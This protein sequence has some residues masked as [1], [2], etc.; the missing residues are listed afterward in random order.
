[1]H[2]SR[3]DELCRR[4][5]LRRTA[6]LS[7]VGA[8]SSYALGLAG[9]GEL[10]AQAGGGGYQ[11]LVC[12]FLFG[13]N[14]HSNTL[15]PYDPA[16][17]SRYSSLRGGSTGVAIPQ[18]HLSS[19]VLQPIEQQTLTDDQVLALAP[20]L[21]KLKARF[22]E[23]VMAPI[24]NVG[25]L[26][27]PLTRA[28]YESSNTRAYP[29][30]SKL[31]SHNDQRST[32]LSFQ[33][34]GARTGW[35]GLLGDIALSSNRNAM[36]TAI[37]AGGDAVFLSGQDVGSYRI[38]SGGVPTIYN[39][40]SLYNSA[41]AGSALGTLLRQQSDHVLE[42]DHAFVTARSIDFSGF[43]DE[44]LQSA[45]SFTDFP[46]NSIL[47]QQLSLVSQLI[48]AHGDLG[49]TRQ[50][51]LVSMGGF[52]N[53]SDLKSTHQGLLSEVDE[54]LD[55]F[56]SVLG[57]LGLQNNVTTFTASDFGR[58]LTFNGRGSDH[59][60]GGHHF[61]LGGAVKGGR[62][63]GTAPHISTQTDDQVGRGRLLPTIAVDQY[64]ATLAKWLGV[65]T[66]DLGY[67]APNIG[68]FETSDL[69]FMQV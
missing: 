43:V 33:P 27:A 34:E 58:S 17:Y 13:G 35:G 42:N 12:V 61:V 20:T 44:A 18:S 60:W 14:D 46:S 63:Y 11:A 28:Q 29:R 32:W 49:V 52:D 23:G 67:V 47:S 66:A 30:P 37:N 62:F 5:F 57:R 8:G 64:A 2:V 26:L 19:T 15:I 41:V 7:A 24:L 54:A 22:D 45:P 59:G 31:F 55:Q 3:S 68:R 48:A 51:F 56:Y 39:L 10:A 40:R 53:H 6:A 38:R 21:P 1:M 69:G 9:L 50:I 36:F 16:N 25:P 65:R 4:M